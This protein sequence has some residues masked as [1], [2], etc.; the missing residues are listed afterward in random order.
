MT[1]TP[2]PWKVSR[3]SAVMVDREGDHERVHIC[4]MVDY[5]CCQDA[6]AALIA[7]APEM[8]EALE[9]LV[10][11]D[12]DYFMVDSGL[13]CAYCGEYNGHDETCLIDKARG[14]DNDNPT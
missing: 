11:T 7:A 10:E 4:V 8:L 14:A 12:S 2:G 9:E 6:N 3:K 5:P 13:G 1:H